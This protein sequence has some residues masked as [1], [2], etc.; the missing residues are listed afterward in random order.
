M[1][2]AGIIAAGLIA[3]V[4][5]DRH[6]ARCFLPV[7]DRLEPG[8]ISRRARAVARD[9]LVVD[10]ALIGNWREVI[11]PGR[12]GRDSMARILAF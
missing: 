11:P 10:A 3:A 1:R 6:L 2:R 8:F 12:R 4:R 7:A 9:W 5:G